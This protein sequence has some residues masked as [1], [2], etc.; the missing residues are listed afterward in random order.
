[1]VDLASALSDLTTHQRQ[2]VDWGEGAMLV[3]AGPGSGKTRVLTCR[4]ARLL[5]QSEAKPFRIL[6]L[7]F[8]N[9]AADEMRERVEGL[10]PGQSRRLFLGTFHAFCAEILRQ[11]GSHVGFKP[12][13]RI[14]A[15]DADR[16]QVLKAAVA[17]ARTENPAVSEDDESLLPVIDRLRADLITPEESPKHVVAE[18]LKLRIATVYEHFDR[19]LRESNGL[20]FN[21]LIYVACDLLRRFPALAKRYRTVY[22]YWCIDEFQDTNLAQYTLVKLLAGAEFR[23]VFAVA[24]D[25]Q[26]IY[27]WNGASYRRI[28]DFRADF[29]P[30][31]IQLPTNFRCPPEIVTLANNLIQ[32]NTLRSAGKVP[33]QSGRA[34]SQADGQVVRAFR[35][36][37]EAEEARWVSSEIARRPAG[38]RAQIA[39]LARTRKLVDVVKSELT[40]AGV[41]ASIARRRDEFASVP[42]T[43]LHAAMRL[44]NRRTDRRGLARLCA[45]FNS[46]TELQLESESIFAAARATHGDSL[47]EFC[48]AARAAVAAALHPLVAEIERDLVLSTDF[49]AFVTFVLKWFETGAEIAIHRDDPMS[50]FNEDLR[51]WREIYPSIM[52]SLGAQGTLETFLQELDLRSKEPAPSPDAVT[53]M[54]IHVA[55][56]KEFDH[57]FLMGLAEDQL[58]SFQAKKSG[59]SSPEMEEERRNCFVA[60]TRARKTITITFANSY[61]GWSKKPSRFLTEMGFT[62]A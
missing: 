18:R 3:L 60:I 13:F 10:A 2:A 20:D 16:E 34:P 22:P 29:K 35:F 7:T 8:T 30:E 21:S 19:Q 6:G 62:L 45:A 53:L 12:D 59:D 42:F 11:H 55:K 36:S 17:R 44:A 38:E 32:H 25:D 14:Y 23:N 28:E 54:T 52:Q 50:D 27:Q 26:V 49:R 40:K 48:A 33:V 46:L 47:R 39:V 61:F 37:D 15:T 51:A 43:F 56:G 57:V 24:D 58:P 5:L 4:I 41:R 1:M 9:K 31:V